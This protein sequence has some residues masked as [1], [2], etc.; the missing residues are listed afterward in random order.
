[1][2]WKYCK[3]QDLWAPKDCK[4]L[5][6]HASARQKRGGKRSGGKSYAR[7]P[8]QAI[9]F[10]CKCKFEP[11]QNYYFMQLQFLRFSELILHK[12]FVGWCYG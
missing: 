4:V 10:L 2:H 1:M 12:L 9:N 3:F 11:Q 6:G 7:K 5:G 8:S